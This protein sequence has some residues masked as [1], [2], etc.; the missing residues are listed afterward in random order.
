MKRSFLRVVV[1]LGLLI[2]GQQSFGLS[3]F[4]W[5]ATGPAKGAGANPNGTWD[6]D[7]C[8]SVRG[9]FNENATTAPEGQN[10]E[11]VR[12]GDGAAVVFSAGN[13]AQSAY[14]V[15][16]AGKVIARNVTVQEGTVTLDGGIL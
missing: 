3:T 4:F 13:D 9:G 1:L 7:A 6:V 2:C 12:W 14:R 8:W 11:Q 5:D 16:I 15:Q 10:T